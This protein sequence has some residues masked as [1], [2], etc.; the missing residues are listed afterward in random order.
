MDEPM[1]FI[2]RI[3]SHK[4]FVT[5]YVKEVKTTIEP[6]FNMFGCQRYQRFEGMYDGYEYAYRSTLE[7]NENLT[8]PFSFEEYEMFPKMSVEDYSKY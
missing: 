6:E 8:V 5:N 1:L 2:K 7:L 3:L 4:R